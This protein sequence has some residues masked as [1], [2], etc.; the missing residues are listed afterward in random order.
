MSQVAIVI[1]IYTTK[2]S[3]NEWIS[4]RQCA[5]TLNKHPIFIV[6]PN[7]ID[8]SIINNKIFGLYEE[9]FN[10]DYFRSIADYN[11]LML[12][13]V[14]YRRFE[15]YK[16]ILIHQTDAYVFTDQLKKRCDL[17]YDYI[18]APWTPVHSKYDKRFGRF[19]LGTKLFFHKIRNKFSNKNLLYRVGNGGFS[20]R[21][22]SKF[23][24]IVTSN[25]KKIDYYLINK[26]TEFNEDVFFSYEMNKWK[27]KIT[28]PPY[29]EAIGF[30]FEQNPSLAFKHNN[31]KLPFGCHAWYKAPFKEFWRAFISI[32]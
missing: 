20:L 15:K 29:K 19:I 21:K 18:G 27:T 25:Q 6:A 8:L 16:Y 11:R 30:A 2:L 17:D 5:K 3:E 9:R 28:T 23:I 10:D 31:N 26:G 4:L 32:K 12:S 1:P 13:E 7:S 14:F 24:A 22:V